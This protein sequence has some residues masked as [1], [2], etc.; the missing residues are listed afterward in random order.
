[1]KFY[2]VRDIKRYK[3][4]KVSCW[5]CEKVNVSLFLVLF[6]VKVENMCLFTLADATACFTTTSATCFCGNVDA[7]QS[8]FSSVSV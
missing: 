2:F 7:C 3:S 5:I 4:T 1:L 8:S 6:P